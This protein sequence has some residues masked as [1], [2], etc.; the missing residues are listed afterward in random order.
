MLL[1][2]HKYRI[3]N[4]ISGVYASNMYT[5]FF[6]LLTIDQGYLELVGKV[7][8]REGVEVEVILCARDL[9]I[10]IT[11]NHDDH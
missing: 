8:E 10:T 7:K 11:L 9:K 3:L 5:T 2:I 1:S 6:S 4:N